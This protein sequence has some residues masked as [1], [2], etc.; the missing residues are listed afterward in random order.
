M[1]THPKPTAVEHDEHI[2]SDFRWLPW[3]CVALIALAAV[4]PALIL[5]FMP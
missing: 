5:E 4:A 1:T 3:A 2:E